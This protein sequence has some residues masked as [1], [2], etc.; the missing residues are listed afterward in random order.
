MACPRTEQTRMVPTDL[1]QV[2][3][4]GIFGREGNKDVAAFEETITERE[5]ASFVRARGVRER[6]EN[7]LPVPTCD[8]PSDLC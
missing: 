1:N 8:A 3:R 6:Q 4:R 5:P 7:H 2:H